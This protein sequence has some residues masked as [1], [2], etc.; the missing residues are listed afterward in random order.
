MGHGHH[1]S[2]RPQD[3]PARGTCRLQLV[4]DEAHSAFNNAKVEGLTRRAGL[5]YPAA[6]LRRFGMV[7]ECGLDRTVIDQLGAC[8]FIE[9]QNIV[10]QG[11]TG[12]PGSP[13]STAWWPSMLSASDPRSHDIHMPNLE[14]PVAPAA[15]ATG[16][17]RNIEWPPTLRM[18]HARIAA[19]WHTISDAVL[20]AGAQLLSNDP[21]R[22][23]RVKV[24]GI[25]E[26]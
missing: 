14:K 1:P 9:Q 24:P 22:F 4:V 12:S 2:Y 20:A 19:A 6:D 18:T 5:C 16:P 21:A 8:R 23:G 25:D 26:H 3:R 11:F 17:R 13:T 7:E 10:L 15:T